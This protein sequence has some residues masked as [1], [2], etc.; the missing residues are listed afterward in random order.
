[1]SPA[2]ETILE[3]LDAARQKW[4]LFSLMTTMVLALCVSGGMMM[5]F[6][7]ADAYLRFSKNGLIGLSITWLAVTGVLLY[8]VGR[9]LLRGQRSL[10]ATAR[11]VEVKFPEIGSH[12][13]NL[14]Q[15]AEDKKNVNQAFCQ[16]A[17]HEAASQL[18]HVAFAGAAAQESSWG[19]F[20]H[21]M[22]TPRDLAVACVLL[23]ALA[24][25]AMACEQKIPNWHSAIARL[26]APWKFVP[27]AGSVEIVRVVPGDVDV[28]I[29][30]SQEISV[31]IK[32][33]GNLSHTATLFPTVQ[34]EPESALPMIEDESRQHYTLTLPSIL[35]PLT[36]RLEI[37]D[38][39]TQQY[40]ISVR[41]KPVVTDAEVTYHFPAYLGRSNETLSHAQLD[42][43]APQYTEVELLLHVSTP[44]RKGFVELG[45]KPYPGRVADDGQSMT[46]QFPLLKDGTYIIRLFN[47]AGHTDS[48][49]RLNR[50]KV[51]PDLP[52]TVELLKP[53]QHSTATPGSEIPVAIRAG[54][55]H[56]IHH[57]RL[58]MKIK[59]AETEAKQASAESSEKNE[60][61]NTLPE[62]N[63]AVTVV[64][65]WSDFTGDS[66]TTAVRR[67]ALTLKP[68]TVKPGQT[69]LIR[70][71]AGDNRSLNDWGLNL[72]SQET[73]CGWHTIA[74]VDENAKANDAVRQIEGLRT[75]LWQLL[76]K[77]LHSQIALLNALKKEPLP[78]RQE[79][80]GDVRGQQV[81]IQKTTTSLLSSIGSSDQP[82]NRVIKRTL[83]ALAAGDMLQ[84]VSCCDD[85]LKLTSPE[86]FAPGAAQLSAAQDRI[87]E[88]LRKL[89]DVVRHAESEA[90]SGMK[91]RPDTQLPDDVKQKYQEMHDKLEKFLEQQKKVI[92]ASENLAKTPVEDF[93]K[94][95]EEAL[96]GMAATEDDWS[97]FMSETHSDLSKL[98]EQ[99]FANASMAKELIEIQTELK[100]A[101][102]ALTKKSADIAVPLEQLGYE[103]AEEMKTNLE[104]WLPDT[105]DREKWSQ[106]ESLTDKDK[107]APM[108]E[109]PA[110][111]EDIV[112]ELMEQ[113][114]DLFDEMEDVSS[115][116]IDSLDKGAGW[117]AM[118]GPISDNSAKGVTGNRLPNTSEIG[119]RAGEGRQGKSSGEFVGDEAVGKGGRKTPTRL[120]PDPYVKGQIKDHSKESQGGATGGGKE[121]GKGGEG[122]EGPAARS[123]GDRDAERL[124]GKQAALR[125][126]AEGL[127]LRFQ[128][129][130]FQHTDVKKM[131]DVMSQVE[132][133]LKA[134]RY[135]NALRQR[136]VLLDGLGNVKQY[137]E[138]EFEV[139]Q[140]ATSNLPAEVQKD[141]LGAMQ[142]PSP[143][144]WEALNR[145][146][147]E[148]LST[149]VSTSGDEKK[150]PAQTE[151]ASK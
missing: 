56:G 126:K 26:M 128:V 3:R 124:A 106:E 19:R 30:S 69:V 44:I 101:E 97:K 122:L 6:M 108:A 40:R 96:K 28:L 110:E 136:K 53:T 105:P 64:H 70:A 91:Q 34:G 49:P 147:F 145:Q 68:E 22:Q 132:R 139:R 148:R 71:V 77:Q 60:P 36:Y 45:S 15:L 27:S 120:T 95:Q 94:E 133:D 66:V 79:G 117:D 18:E 80:V 75:A 41:E 121:S 146:Y 129:S 107:E 20:R 38:T 29:G 98:P 99:D 31:E 118:D 111:L 1:M 52:P 46:V 123:P 112:G 37:G 115:S 137:L 48:S 8:L 114:E 134:G 138:G 39:Q 58:E 84:A 55:D 93:T 47:D 100:M 116:A 131:V 23:T 130:N 140:D 67:Y 9:R 142:D 33:P 16:S 103:M 150:A 88:S 54:D 50:I 35:K 13:I 149:S 89:L 25:I 2:A 5:L 62:E 143:S 57:L 63:Q 109:L 119:G 125:N 78:K 90:L 43:E 86:S 83:S 141:I 10:E 82:E 73:P 11:C 21:C 12:L 76:E 65:E 113:E 102:D 127:D 14:V 135:K 42:L 7:L 151:T 24:A 92:E 51:L 87:I 61:A 4:W 59:Q 104:K 32:N 85:L 81:D 17:V 74:I 72:K 144:G